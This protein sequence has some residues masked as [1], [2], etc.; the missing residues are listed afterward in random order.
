MT[1]EINSYQ[2]VNKNNKMAV[3][4]VCCKVCPMFVS[5]TFVYYIV[6]KP[7]SKYAT[8]PCLCLLVCVRTVI[9]RWTASSLI[10]ELISFCWDTTT[11]ITPLV[12]L[13]S[14]AVT[15]TLIFHG[16]ITVKEEVKIKSNLCTNIRDLFTSQWT[17]T[18]QQLVGHWDVSPY[19]AYAK[20]LRMR[21]HAVL[22]NRKKYVTGKIAEST[23]RYGSENVLRIVIS[24]YF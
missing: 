9:N 23:S 3:L 18:G 19:P 4:P 22:T 1:E 15:L 2:T 14:N 12:C 5:Q 8:R 20:Y 7:N 21:T 6:A 24:K 13:Y 16:R 10:L 11:N 17:G